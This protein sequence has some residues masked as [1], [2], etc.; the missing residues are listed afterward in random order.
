[1]SKSTIMLAQSEDLQM[2][3]YSIGVALLMMAICSFAIGTTEFVTTGLLPNLA[4]DF[5]ITI[6]VAG[7]VTSGYAL[8]VGIGG[9]LLTAGT[10][11]ISRKKVLVSLM[12]LFITGSIVSALAPT[13]AILMVGRF[14]SAFCHGAFFGIGAVVVAS[15]VGPNRSATAIALMFTGLTLANVIG[16]PMGTL[17]GQHFG[18]RSSFWVISVLG[19]IG[20]IG[21]LAFLPSHTI[22]PKTCLRHELA[23]FKRPQVWMALLVTAVGFSGLLASFAYV[24]PMMLYVA[25][26]TPY[27]VG[28]LLGIYGV[29]L[30]IGN[31]LGG[32]AADKALIPTIYGLLTALAILLGIFVFTA[33]YK[34]PAAITLFL[35]GAIG[36]GLVSPLQKYILNKAEGAPTLASAANIAAFNLGTALGVFLGGFTIQIGLGYTSGWYYFNSNRFNFGNYQ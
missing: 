16:V 14:L 8:G 28:W 12:V 29:G 5:D 17:L 20:L 3:S 36:F 1:M 32:R 13:F 19:V 18:W 25:G 4:N 22:V 9:P 2:E 35:L 6:P 30:V 26:Y 23:V 33:H 31:I 24:A 15:M 21:I 7:F 10:L 27:A 11:H 34:I